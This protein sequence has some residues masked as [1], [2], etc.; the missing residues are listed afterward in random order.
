MGL[1]GW[2]KNDIDGL[3]VEFNAEEIKALQFKNKITEVSVLPNARITTINLKK[4]QSIKFSDFRILHDQ[5]TA[6]EAN[7][8]LTPDIALCKACKE[9]LSN[10]AE[11]RYDYPFTSCS[12]CGPRF[13]IIEKLPYD[14]EN[15][16]MDPFKLCGYCMK[17]Y[18]DP[19]ERRYYAQTNSCPSCGITLQLYDSEQ[20]M[21]S[22]ESN[23]IID[24]ILKYWNDGKIIAI[25]GIGGYLLTCDASNGESIKLL[26]NRKNRPSKPLAIMIPNKDSLID[27]EVKE[28]ELS[29]LENHVSPI[30]LLTKKNEQSKNNGIA[31]GLDKVGVMIPYAP[32]FR[33]LLDKFNR[34]VIATSGNVSN[35]TIIYK[36]DNAIIELSQIADYI[37]SNNRSIVIPQDDSVITFTSKENQKII[38]RR[39]R[40]LSP[41]FINS[42]SSWSPETVLCM[43]A[44]LKSTFSLLYKKNVYISQYLGDLDHIESMNN[45]KLVQQHFIDLLSAVPTVLVLDK[46]PNYQSS[47]IGEAL[48]INNDLTV[49]RVQHHVAHFSAIIG[50]YDL[51]DEPEPLLGVIWDGLGLG[52]DGNIWGGEFF[53]YRSHQFHR[54]THLPYFNLLVNDKMAKEPRLS[55]MSLSHSNPAAQQYI[56]EKF[57]DQEWKIYSKILEED[58]HLKTSSMGRLFD[59]IASLLG[60]MDKQTYE[61]EAAM[62][63]EVLARKYFTENDY[64]EMPHYSNGMISYQKFSG[65]TVISSVLHDL[66][67][68]LEKSL[69]AAKFH[70]SLV[71]WIKAIAEKE[72]CKKIAFSGGVFQNTLLVDLIISRL[73]HKFKLYFHE[74]LSPN[75]EN[76]SFGQLI[77]YEITKKI[78]K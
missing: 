26:R 19:L 7:L 13:S 78:K 35:A 57:T 46:H 65:E 15:T 48:S 59:A 67:Q 27:F 63:L 40:G 28:L 1:V 75:D 29:E 69:I 24:L 22:A 17:E 3:H 64:S 49:H 18:S 2:V 5:T 33:V 4:I 41:T 58:D 71:K 54:C 51:I 34:P 73:N 21:L 72:Q 47:I 20:K 37:L 30:V 55:A 36:D 12:H 9:D 10:K 50:E 32:L 53:I 31:D 77:N 42:I 38:L 6:L 39:S 56:R 61:G 74:Q 8:L 25:K 62:H 43:G 76:I 70:G 23:V 16:T 66:K 14:R 11:R 68:G 60:V 45:Y 52:N 44:Q